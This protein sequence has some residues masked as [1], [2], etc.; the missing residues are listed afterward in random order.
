MDNRRERFDRSL[1]L[2]GRAF[3]QALA[4]RDVAVVGLGGVG[5]FAL[6]TLVRSG[7][8]TIRLV[9]RDR[10]EV[11]NFNRQLL[12]TEPGLG[13]LK[14]AAARDRVQSINPACHITTFPV[15]VAPD[16][17]DAFMTPPPDFLLDAI[18][19]PEAKTALLARA[20]ELGVPAVSSMGAAGRFDPASVTIADLSETHSCPLARKVRRLLRRQGGFPDIRC[21][22]S[23]E[24]PIRGLSPRT[25]TPASANRRYGSYI[26][27]TAV[28]GILAAHEIIRGVLRRVDETLPGL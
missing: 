17:L 24:K 1:P 3:Q 18:D 25:E 22:F 16:S 27:V 15:A 28:F 12:A 4:S 8:G 23:T 7:V 26:G 19:D 21:V 20:G 5:S 11:S 14:T 13:T 2:F 10:I 9:D 6:E